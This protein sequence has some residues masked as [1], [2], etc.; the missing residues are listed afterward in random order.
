MPRHFPAPPPGET[1]APEAIASKEKIVLTDLD[2][3]CILKSV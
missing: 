3:F 1:Q 2:H